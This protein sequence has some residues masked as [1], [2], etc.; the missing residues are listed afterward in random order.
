MPP[1]VALIICTMF[2]L[3]LLHLEHKEAPEASFALWIP[4]LWM[5]LIASKPLAVWFG[6]G[7]QDMESGS[8]LDRYFLST[9]FCLGLLILAKRKFNWSTAVRENIWIILIV[10][11]MLVSIFWSAN[12]YMSFKR[13]SRELIAVVM[14]FI[15]LS[16]RNPRQAMQSI[17]MR[18]AYILI[19]FS[20]LLIRYFGYYGRMY[21]RWSGELMWI[22]VTTHKNSLGRLCIIASFFLVWTLVKRWHGSTIPHNKYQ[23]YADLFV[24]ILTFYL[25][26]GP[27]HFYSASSFIALAAGFAIFV[28]LLWRKKRQIT[29]GENTLS[30]IMAFVIGFGVLTPMVGGSTLSG[31]TNTVGRDE[32]LTGRTEIWAKYLPIAL[33]RPILGHGIGGFWSTST[34]E[35]M[36]VKEAHNGYLEIIMDLGFLGLLLVSIYLISCCR[37]AKKE[38]E[39]DF[40]WGILWICFLF[41]V[42]IHNI[43]E[44]S[45]NTLASQPMATLLFLSVCSTTAT[46]NTTGVST[47]L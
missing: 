21:H 31:L 37:K 13:W 4:T 38:L 17:L 44:S 30:I 36:T 16:E 40:Y 5:L 46:S 45:L 26:K 33:K 34:A 23:T 22:G 18:C 28:A 14:A 39:H 35:E 12:P 3:W 47:W 42:A 20:L 7:G 10:S 25:L 15:V 24:L 19:P 27:S 8:P 11:Y 29:L 1:K 9:L 32:T 41:I 2:V 6:T 43:A